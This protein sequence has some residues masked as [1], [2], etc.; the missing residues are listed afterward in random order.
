MTLQPPAEWVGP[1]QL[2]MLEGCQVPLTVRFGRASAP[3]HVMLL[4]FGPVTP[5]GSIHGH[6]LA[7]IGDDRH[8]VHDAVTWD[9]AIQDFALCDYD[10]IDRLAERLDLVADLSGGAGRFLLRTLEVVIDLMLSLMTPSFF[11]I[12]SIGAILGVYLIYYL[13]LDLLAHWSFYCVLLPGAVLGAVCLTI[14]NS[15]LRTLREAVLAA[16]RAAFA[17]TPGTPWRSA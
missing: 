15:R 2:Q 4:R 16:A 5:G 8:V 12:G 1:V 10:G 14:R 9:D 7:D 17:A 13:L 6:L 3:C 11:V